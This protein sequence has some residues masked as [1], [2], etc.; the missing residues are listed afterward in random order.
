MASTVRSGAI[1][2]IGVYGTDRYGVSNVTYTPDGVFATGSS[3]SGVVIIG[4]ALS[5]VVGVSC[6]AAVGG[7]GVVGVAV[8]N[9]IGVEATG[10]VNDDVSFKLDCKFEVNGFAATTAVGDVVIAADANVGL[11]GVAAVGVVGDVV[12]AADAVTDVTGVEATA[13]LGTASQ[14]TINRI[15]VDGVE[16]V[17]AVG[18]VVIV[19]KANIGLDGVTSFGVVNNVIVRAASNVIM[20]GVVSNTII[21]DNIT[22]KLD[23]KF[24]VNGV[25]ST[26]LIGV[27]AITTTSFDYEA[28]KDLYDRKRTVFVERGT[29]S[30]DRT[31]YVDSESRLVYVE[32]RPVREVAVN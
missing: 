4:D 31:V 2:G 11:N 12:I 30:A 13:I 29:T 28:V 22:Y 3:D 21:N 16:A 19:A 24:G 8:T 27:V 15:E 25:L 26:G 10:F 18:N 6:T 7:V 5:V 9:A 23:C 32:S 20:N 14:R 17:G 1:Y